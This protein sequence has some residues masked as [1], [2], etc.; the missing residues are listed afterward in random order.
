MTDLET[1]L[2][3]EVIGDNNALTEIQ[4]HLNDVCT[5]W[6]LPKTALHSIIH[7]K[8]KRKCCLWMS[9]NSS[10]VELVQWSKRWLADTD[11]DLEIQ[12]QWGM[13]MIHT[14]RIWE[15]VAGSPKI[16][17]VQSQGYLIEEEDTQNNEGLL[18]YLI[19]KI[20]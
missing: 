4:Q 16:I 14:R 7:Q 12:V 13:V 15:K 5:G 8:I 9:W 6:N 10:C 18:N 19:A 3:S 2:L 1:D 17:E 20:L 11:I